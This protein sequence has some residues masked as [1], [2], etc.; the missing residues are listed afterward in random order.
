MVV[1][2][3][4]MPVKG[5]SQESPLFNRFSVELQGGAMS[6]YGDIKRYAY[7]PGE[8][9]TFGGSLGLNYHVSPV[10]T[11]KGNFLTGK[12]VGK[13]LANDRHFEN[14]FREYSLNAVI[15]FNQMFLPN[16]RF[17]ENFS[18][19]GLVGT[20]MIGYRS[21]LMQLSDDRVIGTVRYGSDNTTPDGLDW[22]LVIPFGLGMKF[23]VSPRVDLGIE[24]VFRYSG[25][26]NLDAVSRVSS[27]KDMYN[28]TS[29]G[30]TIHLGRHKQSGWWTRASKTIYAGDV[31]RMDHMSGNFSQVQEKVT[32]LEQ[33]FLA[34]DYDGDISE[35]RQLLTSLDRKNQ[36]LTMRL[37]ELQQ[38]VSQNAGAVSLSSIYFQINS[39]SL[40]AGNYERVAAAA[41][42]LR[43]NPNI[44]MEVIGHTD[45]SGPDQFNKVLSERRAKAV[46]DALVND[47]R[48][49]ASRLSISY[50][51][52][53]D[54]ISEN[55]SHINRRVDF[56]LIR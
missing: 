37:H 48:I 14:H 52:P 31:Q 34:N 23:K 7:W 36:D 42:V 43:T 29:L 33:S 47:F 40:D 32:Q 4:M 56:K 39:A 51:G 27:R 1:L 3:G 50:M 24:S 49:D 5:Q 21:R 26:D 20:G 8:E 53:D 22:D 30:I 9:L 19:Y 28:K 13:S 44:K 17:N 6:H 12:M 55:K 10:L 46:F 41:H 18:I 35:L 54:P 25:T 2:A 15:N 16:G 38:Q 11:L 45:K